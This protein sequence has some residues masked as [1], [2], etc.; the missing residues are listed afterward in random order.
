MDRVN[1]MDYDGVGLLGHSYEG[2]QDPW[3]DTMELEKNQDRIQAG[4]GG[5]RYS[6]Q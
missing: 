5:W 4:Y 6:H 3:M 1:K 2:I